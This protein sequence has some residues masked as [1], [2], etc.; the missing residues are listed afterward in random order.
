MIVSILQ[1]VICKILRRGLVK[2]S[3]PVCCV[4]HR[5]TYSYVSQGR[6]WVESSSIES[7]PALCGLVTLYLLQ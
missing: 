2:I 7:T 5:A 3:F 6:L 1:N 4:L